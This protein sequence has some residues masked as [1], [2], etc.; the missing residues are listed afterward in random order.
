MFNFFSYQYWLALLSLL[1]TLTAFADEQDDKLSAQI[2]YAYANYLGTGIY[3]AADRAVQVYHIPFSVSYREPEPP[4][5]GLT[6][7]LPV[8]AGFINFKLDEIVEAGLPTRIETLTFVPGVAFAF[9]LGENWTVTPFANLGG[10][11]DFATNHSALVYGVGVKSMVTFDL[12]KIDFTLFNE[13]LFAGN[14]TADNRGTND[15][16]RLET[17]FSFQKPLSWQVWDRKTAL[18]IYYTNFMYTNSLEFL[19]FADNSFEI[20][21]QNEVGITFDTDPNMQVAKIG[22]SGIG[23]GY[24]FGNKISVYRL[25]FGLPF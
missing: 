1:F 16:S 18:R 24:R 14:T 6:F 13:F 7:R 25:V 20:S 9:R 17:G 19:Q 23:I 11:H 8:T 10:G 5:S 3:S 4:R 22:F 15:F 21:A 12:G 2:N